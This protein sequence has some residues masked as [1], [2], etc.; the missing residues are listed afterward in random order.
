MI[1]CLEEQAIYINKQVYLIVV[2]IE[3]IFNIY[4]Y[5]TKIIHTQ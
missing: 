1:R 5:A 2:A 3:S 4:I